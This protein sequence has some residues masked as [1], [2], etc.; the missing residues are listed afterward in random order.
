MSD[1]NPKN[2]AHIVAQHIVGQL[3]V[4]AE[5]VTPE[6]KLADLGAD[7]L[8]VVEIVMAVETELN[9]DIPDE[10]I[11]GVTTV[12]QLVAV[13]EKAQHVSA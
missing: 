10:D 8:D 5:D 3:G 6:A 9:V 11:D 12:A 13:A 7:S 4:P 1:L 2:A